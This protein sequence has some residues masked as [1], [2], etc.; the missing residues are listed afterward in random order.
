MNVPKIEAV[1]DESNGR[2]GVCFLCLIC[3]WF[4]AY[5]SLVFSPCYWWICLLV[6]SLYSFC[7]VLFFSPLF[8]F[9]EHVYVSLCDFVCLG[10][11]L[12]FVLG[13][14]L[15]PFFF[16]FRFLFLVVVVLFWL[17]VFLFFFKDCVCV[18][19][20][21][22]D[23]VCLVL[24]LPFVLGFYL[25]V[26]FFLPFLPS[27]VASRVLVLQLGVVPEPPRWEKRV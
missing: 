7:F 25:F 4:Y 23:F 19:V 1:G 16:F 3:F 9:C 10:V 6:W 21:L 17:L 8:S 13:F 26:V 2:L 14:C 5:L 24:P 15:S 11:L 20:S 22:C 18:Y 12:P 27:H